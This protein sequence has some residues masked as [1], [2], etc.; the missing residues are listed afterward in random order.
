MQWNAIQEAKKRGKSHYNFWGVEPTGN[1]KHPWFGL[2]LFKKG[3][4]GNLRQ[5]TGANDIPLKRRYHITRTFEIIR[6]IKRYKS[7]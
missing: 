4:G 7:L 6:R 2:S 3:F 1:P 5:F